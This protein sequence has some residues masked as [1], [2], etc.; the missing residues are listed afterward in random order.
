[1]AA[2]QSLSTENEINCLS[3]LKLRDRDKESMRVPLKV[4]EIGLQKSE[5]VEP[6]PVN[7]GVGNRRLHCLILM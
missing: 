7:A 5:T 6:D 1:M 2:E 3:G 4:A